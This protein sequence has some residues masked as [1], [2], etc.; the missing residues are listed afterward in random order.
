M[1]IFCYGTECYNYETDDYE[2]EASDFGVQ[3]NF[4]G[5]ATWHP[6]GATSSNVS[7]GGTKSGTGWLDVLNTLAGQTGAI[8]GGTKNPRN[9]TG[10]GGV[11]PYP[12]TQPAKKGISGL[13]IF[14]IVAGTALLV[15]VI[16]V[17][18]K[19]KK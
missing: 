7:S 15:T 5:E 6:G 9:T 14:G 13:A 2:G 1:R 11:Y 18:A 19:K 12:T 10:T 3:P 16:V 4:Q 17:V 8:F